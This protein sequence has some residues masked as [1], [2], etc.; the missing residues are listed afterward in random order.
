MKMKE[1]FIVRVLQKKIVSEIQNIKYNKDEYQSNIDLTS[2]KQDVSP[3]LAKLLSYISTKL[4]ENILIGNMITGL[5]SNRYTSLQV[6]LAILVQ[7][8]QL[9]NQLHDYGVV[10][11]YDEL[12]CGFE[13]Q[14][15]FGVQIS[16]HM[17]FFL[18]IPMALFKL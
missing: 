11:S 2:C 4:L 1:I 13:L 14:Q 18:T 12:V 7:A 5:V 16:S 10:C 17:V 9:V 8:K 3:A 6:S 15:Q